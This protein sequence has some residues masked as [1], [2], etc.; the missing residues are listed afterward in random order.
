MQSAS[1]EGEKTMATKY[2]TLGDSVV[3]TK[4]AEMFFGASRANVIHEV[5]DVVRGGYR[6]APINGEGVDF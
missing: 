5:T 4:D 2:F 6:I 3:I 1:A